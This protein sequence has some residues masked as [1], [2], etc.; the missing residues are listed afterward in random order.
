MIRWHAAASD[1]VCLT[2]CQGA[3]E[4]HVPAKFL[5]ISL[6]KRSPTLEG[7]TGCAETA[8][9]AT[10]ASAAGSWSAGASSAA[11]VPTAARPP[12]TAPRPAASIPA[13]SA[14]AVPPPV[15]ATALPPAARNP[16]E[17]SVK[18][19]RNALRVRG[20][21]SGPGRGGV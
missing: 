20:V 14:G 13:P 5:R 2:R 21:R 12:V 15:A 19:L 7:R 9:F 3:F 8:A 6:L 17:M 18:E 10:G 11:A 16:S 1:V 4:A